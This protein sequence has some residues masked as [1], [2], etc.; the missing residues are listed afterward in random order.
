M[1]TV[2]IYREQNYNRPLQNLPNATAV[3]VLGILSIVLVCCYGVPSIILGII[4]LVLS[5]KDIKLYNADPAAY[6]IR[7]YKNLKAG[8]TC[9][10]IGL[11]LFGLSVIAVIFVI[12]TIGFAA[13]T[14]PSILSQYN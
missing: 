7:S 13:L 1:E 11:V 8:K 9:A 10:I 12:A 5:S 2:D 4:A 3:L 14:N 6:T